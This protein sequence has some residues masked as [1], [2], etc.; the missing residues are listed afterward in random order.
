MDSKTFCPLPWLQLASTTDGYYRPCCEFI[1]KDGD[2]VAHWTDDISFYKS[3]LVTVKDDLLN[4]RRPVE[5]NQCWNLEDKGVKSLRKAILNNP[6]YQKNID[7]PPVSIDIK[8]GNL[9]NLGCRM[10]DPR[11]SSVLQKEILNNLSLDWDI[12][13]INSAQQ[14]YTK[15][16]WPELALKQISKIETLE[17][18]KFTGGEPFAIP[19]VT[20]FLN[21]IKNPN[22]VS[23]EFST[24]VLLISKKKIELLKKFKKVL[25]NVSCDGIKNSYEYIRW[26]GKWKNFEKQLQYIQNTT[27]LNIYINVTVNA[28]NVY[29][30][31]ELLNY[32]YDK[33]LKVNIIIVNHPNYLHPWIYPKNLKEQIKNKYHHY[34]NIRYDTNLDIILKHDIIYDDNLY[35][36]FLKQ[37]EIKDKLRS[38][39]FDPFGDLYDV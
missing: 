20:K 34:L 19:Y 8:L 15:N 35:Q 10:C 4:N 25:L 3:K 22:E 32:F 38:Q 33:N 18:F 1:W 36:I 37:K 7:R 26:P 24:N 13:D 30:L 39:I 23:L 2:K 29:V 16:N 27:D 6:L 14:N 11:A 12:E 17:H 28:Y 5:C 9:C 31:P 21:S